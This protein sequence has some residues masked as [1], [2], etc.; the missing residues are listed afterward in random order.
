MKD[1]EKETL[2]S[3]EN[4]IET[5][6]NAIN[7]GSIKPNLYT[8]KMITLLNLMSIELSLNNLA[9][10]IEIETE[11]KFSFKELYKIINKY[12]KKL[13]IKEKK[14]LIKYMALSNLQINIDKPYIS[15]FSLFEYFSQLLNRKIYSLSLIIY[16]ISIKIKN[17]YKKSTLEFF[18]S[19]S[20]EASGE[21]NL[22]GL[23]NLFYKKLNIDELTTTIFYKIVNYNNKTKI[24]IED[25]ILII[26]SYRDD[27]SNDILNDKD[28]N[29]LYLNIILDKNFINIDKISKKEGVNISN[30]DF[31]KII[32]KEINKSN[33]YHNFKDKINENIIEDIL[34]IISQDEKINVEDLKKNIVEAKAKLKNKKIELNTTQKYWINKYIDILSSFGITPEMQYKKIIEI[35]NENNINDNDNTIEINDLKENMLNNILNLEI[36]K[37]E[38]DNIVKSFNINYNGF[39]NYS[40]YKTCINIV[41]KEKEEILKLEY[42]NSIGIKEAN[43]NISNLWE[44]GVRPDYSYLLPIKG[45]SNVLEKYNRNIK[46][47]I[48]NYNQNENKVIKTLDKSQANLRTIGTISSDL[49]AFKKGLSIM[50]NEEY[51]DEYF[52]K[53]ALENFNFNRN[54]FPCFDLINYLVEKED[55][56]NNYSCEI[57][58]YL[59]EDNDGYINVVDLIK[60]SL[61]QLKHKPTKLV[62]KYLYIKIYKELNLTS[63]EE[64]FKNYNIKLSDKIEEQKLCKFF[65]DLNIEFPL[66][67]QIL[68]EIRFCNKP[69]LIYEYL[70]DFI[71]GYK[72]DIYINNLLYEKKVVDKNY[73]SKLFEQEIK[74]NI[75]YIEDKKEDNKLD[76]ELK[77][78]LQNCDDKMDYSKYK[79]DFAEPLQ[80]D[81][82]FSLILFQLLKTFSKN[83][84]QEISKNDLLI[85][86]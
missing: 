38:L 71:E 61:H 63:C 66:T 76:D 68:N 10:K 86:F 59:D 39:I 11:G 82:F 9:E 24:K 46:D 50:N 52:L 41:L 6:I 40:Q 30:E 45:N 36:N 17:I 8:Q 75:N 1:E 84:V 79:K 49:T 73:N 4:Y 43:N 51:N 77:K 12:Y 32:M 60:F 44:Y 80:L 42:N 83:G 62:Y 22:D 57:I 28:K 47:I 72:N 81:E 34:S 53:I 15:L 7:T 64:F 33:K 3:D 23:I 29:V 37:N 21:I 67:K 5:N 31:K 14:S 70:S 2:K 20:W 19:N 69:P 74:R 48:S 16:E 25:I 78:I 65:K 13:T 27:N 56:S 18:I 58:K 35:N 26:D 85:F 55:F 54:H